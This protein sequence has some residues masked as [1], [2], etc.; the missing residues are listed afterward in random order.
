MET[1]EGNI[2]MIKKG[3]ITKEEVIEY[4]ISPKK[5]ELF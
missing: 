5:L 3:E 4:V 2:K 1:K